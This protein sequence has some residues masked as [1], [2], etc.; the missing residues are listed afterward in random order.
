MSVVLHG[1]LQRYKPPNDIGVIQFAGFIPDLPDFPDF[2]ATFFARGV[3]YPPCS[4]WAGADF[5]PGGR[6]LEDSTK[7]PR[8]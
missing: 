7:T 5:G 2:F 6:P 3:L 1:Q 4:G 8:C